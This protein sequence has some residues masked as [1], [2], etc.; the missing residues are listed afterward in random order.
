MI[1]ET[2]CGYQEIEGNFK[3][4]KILASIYITCGKHIIHVS[5]LHQR[6]EFLWIAADKFKSN[7]KMFGDVAR[8]I[9]K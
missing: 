3:D 5:I 6:G 9:N 1:N 7:R 8:S 4:L 2:N